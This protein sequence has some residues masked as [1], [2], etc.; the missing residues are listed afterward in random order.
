MDKVAVVILNW[1]GSGMLRRFLPGVLRCT[2]AD[3]GVVWLADNGSTDDSVSVVSREFPSVRLI[4]LE[5]NYGF[6]E[7]YNRALAQVAAEYVVLL[8][9]DVEVTE[10]WLRPLLAYMEAH[11]EVAACQPKILS[12]HSRGQFEYAGASGG[13]IDRYGYPF[14]RGRVM[15]EVEEDRG[16]YDTVWRRTG[17]STI[18]CLLSFGHRVLRCS[19]AGKTIWKPEVWT[20]GSSP[21]WRRL[22]F[23]GVFGLVDG[24]WSAFPKVWSTT[25]A[26]PP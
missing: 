2:E 21:T 8:N 26:Q 4:R 1:N 12:Y 17:A 25:W 11:P 19:S 3:G 20:D 7:G 22:T 16:Q 15:S 5:K 9:S 13:F 23:A 24:A 6:A 14:C 10:H 18:R